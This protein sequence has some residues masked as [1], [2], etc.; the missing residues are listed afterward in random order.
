MYF[1]MLLDSLQKIQQNRAQMPIMLACMIEN[2]ALYPM[3]ASHS[4]GYSDTWDLLPHMLRMKWR[5]SVCVFPMLDIRSN[6]IRF[7]PQLTANVRQ[8]RYLRR[9]TQTKRW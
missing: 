9:E 8:R 5:P 2:E 4:V 6:T 7:V 3:L 1:M